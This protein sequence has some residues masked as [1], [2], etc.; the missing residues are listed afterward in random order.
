[1]FL[2]N[3]FELTSND[4]M[5]EE[6]DDVDW[7]TNEC[8]EC[9][10]IIPARHYALREPLQNGGWRGCYCNHCLS[11]LLKG[12]KNEILFDRIQEQLMRIGIRNQ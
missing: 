8:T 3:E 6:P 1:M 10:I 2:C 12:S 4:L 11:K 7:F 9:K 5:A